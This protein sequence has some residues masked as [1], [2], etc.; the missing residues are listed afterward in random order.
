MKGYKFISIA[1]G[2]VIAVH[3]ILV[4][5]TY[6]SACSTRIAKAARETNTFIDAR[7]NEKLRSLILFDDGRV[8]G[9]SLTT[10]S[11]LRRV[12]GSDV[13]NLADYYVDDDEKMPPDEVELIE[14]DENMVETDEEES[15]DNREWMKLPKVEE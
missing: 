14:D 6:G 1:H 7:G 15:E 11:L 5:M 10:K 13:K 12:N 3:R 8:V 9:S 2:N 4:I